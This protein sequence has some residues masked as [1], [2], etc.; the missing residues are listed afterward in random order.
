M[1]VHIRY[2]GNHGN[3]LFQYVCARLFADRNGL[4][5]VTPWKRL[6][7]VKMS[8]SE[9][10]EFTSPPVTLGDENQDILT[11]RWA[12]GRYLFDGY[13]QSARGSW[14]HER[15]QDIKAFAVPTPLATDINREDIAISLRVR[16]DYRIRNLVIHPDWYVD[17]LKRET[18]RKIYI[19]ADVIDELYIKRITSQF[20]NHDVSVQAEGAVEDWKTL[21]SFDRLVCSNSTFAWWASFFSNASRIYIFRRWTRQPQ[22]S[23]FAN[24]VEVD[25]PFL[26]ER[27]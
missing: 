6:D 23:G 21:R 18:F 25:G 26:S 14:Y 22:L 12:P 4:R 2:R 13:F 17:V 20:P 24:G 9:G 5:V 1:S 27:E 7:I 15:R 8:E 19:I 10:E 16:E 3:N 11:R